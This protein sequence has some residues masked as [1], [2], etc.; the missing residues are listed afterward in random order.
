M[1]M[2][3]ECD[4]CHCI[5]A[6]EY[7]PNPYRSS[8]IVR[9]LSPGQWRPF[10]SDERVEW[11]DLCSL[12]LDALKDFFEGR[13]VAPVVVARHEWSESLAKQ[14]EANRVV[15]DEYHDNLLGEHTKKVEK[16]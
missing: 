4:R 10:L 15:A 9:A 6:P 8:T 16:K 13:G 1:T 12:C 11:A 3:R 5:F 7:Q 14:D 2:R